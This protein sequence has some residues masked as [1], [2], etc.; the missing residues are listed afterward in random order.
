SSPLYPAEQLA[1]RTLDVYVPST[2]SAMS[3]EG[4]SMRIL[5]ALQNSSIESN[6]LSIVIATT[7]D[8]S[9][10]DTAGK[11]QESLATLI[12]NGEKSRAEPLGEA[13]AAR[14]AM[15]KSPDY[16][17]QIRTNQEQIDRIDERMGEIENSRREQ[18]AELGSLL[19]RQQSSGQVNE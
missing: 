18:E 10:E 7:V 1:K 6:G 11:F 13:A 3:K 2:L 14:T 17:K 15:A 4:T 5:R 8:A 12:L 16:E 9:A 19:Q